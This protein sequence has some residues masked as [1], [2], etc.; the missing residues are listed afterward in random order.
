VVGNADKTGGNCGFR[1]EK[2]AIF[3]SDREKIVILRVEAAAGIE[4]GERRAEGR[5]GGRRGLKS[6]TRALKNRSQNRLEAKRRR[7]GRGSGGTLTIY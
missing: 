5:I 4:A 2:N 7:V 6:M 1:G 3:R